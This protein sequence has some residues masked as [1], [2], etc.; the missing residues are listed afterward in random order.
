MLEFNDIYK[1]TVAGKR[2]PEFAA[3]EER[4]AYYELFGI[5]EAYGKRLITKNEATAQK[6]AARLRFDELR[7]GRLLNLGAYTSYQ[8]NIKS[9]EAKLSELIKRTQSGENAEMLLADAFEII[10]L[11]E[12]QQTNS[13]I[14]ILKNR[15]EALKSEVA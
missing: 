2:L 11:L 1:L 5:G 14:H 6:A 4:M 8:N 13:Y 7:E 10:S 9:A 15:A 12:G 3:P